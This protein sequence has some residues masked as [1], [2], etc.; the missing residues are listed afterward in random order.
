MLLP[1]QDPAPEA[2]PL[3]RFDQIAQLNASHGFQEAIIAV[4][5]E[6]IRAHPG[7]R[8]GSL[9]KLC[10]PARAIVDLGEG[11]VV[12]EKLFQLGRMQMLD[13]TSTP[14]DLL[15]LRGSQARVRRC[16]LRAG[17]GW[18]APVFA[19]GRAADSAYFSRPRL[20]MQERIGLN[21]QRFR[22]YKFRT[23][24]VSAQP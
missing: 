8:G 15:R 20:F 16:L 2:S 9:E 4:H 6:A 5:P 7:D 19:L 24:R 21:G 11:I 1:G 18:T 23:M 14:A 12:R 22:M 13:L 17:S 10:L 3:Y